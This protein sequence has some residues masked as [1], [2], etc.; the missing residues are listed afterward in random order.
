M[1]VHQARIYRVLS[2]SIKRI[3]RVGG[4]VTESIV[5]S[6]HETDI[7][8]NTRDGVRA[9][10][11]NS[12]VSHACLSGSSSVF[13]LFFHD[14]YVYGSCVCVC[15]CVCL[16]CLQRARMCVSASYMIALS[17]RVQLPF[18]GKLTFFLF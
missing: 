7:S 12:T 6:E 13:S 15:V 18:Q 11:D 16:P 5:G 4:V 9:V 2:V 10:G 17:V 14:E 1:N 3:Y 8:G